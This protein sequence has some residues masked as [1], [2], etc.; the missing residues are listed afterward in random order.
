[1]RLDA[2][3]IEY[4]RAQL[5]YERLCKFMLWNTEYREIGFLFL[6]SDDRYSAVEIS[7]TLNIP[8]GTVARRL[9]VMRENGLLSETSEGIQHSRKGRIMHVTLHREI[10]RIARE[11]GGA[12]TDLTMTALER[13]PVAPDLFLD[14][15]RDI[16]LPEP[17]KS[18]REQ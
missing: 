4:F 16:D 11:G 10:S 17:F 12:F 14:N 2:D 3:E 9:K 8:R 13:L 7:K 15:L 1:M 18:K 5:V 6:V